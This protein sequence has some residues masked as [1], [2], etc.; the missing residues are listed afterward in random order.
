M[1]K[2]LGREQAITD[3]EYSYW[4]L[5]QKFTKALKDIRFLSHY[6]ET[7]VKKKKDK[8]KKNEKRKR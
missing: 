3:W 2:W 1:K 6:I 4:T 8:G 5:Q 7:E